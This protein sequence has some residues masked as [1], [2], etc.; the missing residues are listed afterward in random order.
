MAAP[1]SHRT[2]DL[3]IKWTKEVLPPVLLEEELPITEKAESTI[4][5]RARRSS[6]FSPAKIAGLLVIVG[7]CS[8]HDTKSRA[9]ICGS[10]QGRDR[11]IFEGF[12]HRD[13]RVFRKAAHD[14]RLEG[15]A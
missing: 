12:V 13:A 15:A 10:S 5:R 3:R 4:F 8:I 11:G 14:C 7:P 2:D 9:R 1:M 6:I